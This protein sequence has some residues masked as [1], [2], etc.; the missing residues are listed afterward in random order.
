MFPKRLLDSLQVISSRSLSLC[1]HSSHF[2]AGR[3]IQLRT[4][5]SS[6]P[7]RLLCQRI[8]RMLLYFQNQL[9]HR[10]EQPAG[11]GSHVGGVG[12]VGGARGVEGRPAGAAEISRRALRADRGGAA[13]RPVPCC[14]DR[15]DARSV[16]SRF[17]VALSKRKTVRYFTPPKLVRKH[18]RLQFAHIV[19]IM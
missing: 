12:G 8:M 16:L 3:W 15:L 4:R 5:L 6:K 11:S 9:G 18:F 1:A 14:V 19:D 17:S 2:S 13:D 7:F 10:R